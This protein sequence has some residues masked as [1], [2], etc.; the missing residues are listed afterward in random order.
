MMSTCD[1]AL[2]ASVQVAH[3]DLQARFELNKW[4]L[5]VVAV[6][7]VVLVVGLA[8]VHKVTGDASILTVMA[9]VYSAILVLFPISVAVMLA[10][11]VTSRQTVAAIIFGLSANFYATFLAPSTIPF[12]VAIVLPI[13]A[14]LAGSLIGFFVFY[15]NVGETI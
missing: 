14:G 10:R 2:I 6:M 7:F 1:T 3:K 13:F 9:G 15:R 11:K 4:F 12:N 5:G 8:L